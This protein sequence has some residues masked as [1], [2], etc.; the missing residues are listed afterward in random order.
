MCT[1]AGH[2]ASVIRVFF[3]PDGSRVISGSIDHSVKIW[4]SE[5]GAEVC[6]PGVCIRWCDEFQALGRWLHSYFGVDLV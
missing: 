2:S 5:T 1:L 4:N 3:S 6:E